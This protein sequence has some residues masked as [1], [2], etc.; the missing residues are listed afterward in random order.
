M[1]ENSLPLALALAPPSPALP[2]TK[3]TAAT[4]GEDGILAHCRSSFSH[5]SHRA[6]ADRIGALTH[7]DTPFKIRIGN[8]ISKFHKVKHKGNTEEN[9]S[10]E[11]TRRKKDLKKTLMK[12]IKI[13]QIKGFKVLVIRMLTELGKK[14]KDTKNKNCNKELKHT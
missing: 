6:L 14:K 1:G 4:P 11:R 3:V 10:N 5:E 2:L 7:K 13:Y 12:Q 9:V 8:Y